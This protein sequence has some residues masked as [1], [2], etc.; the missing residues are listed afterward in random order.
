MTFI[1][2]IP[3]RSLVIFTLGLVIGLHLG[4]KDAINTI[5]KIFDTESVNN[6]INKPTQ[7]TTTNNSVELKKLKVKDSDSIN[8][9]FE[10]ST[11][12]QP[13]QVITSKPCDSI[14]AKLS[15]SETKRL[16][17]WLSK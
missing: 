13:T 3:I 2:K 6:A 17:R 10:P 16:N 8:F 1:K 4:N 7:T 15:K 12:Q 11:S 14:W 5:T 9:S